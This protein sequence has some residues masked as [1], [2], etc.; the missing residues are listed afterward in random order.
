M[1]FEEEMKA[2]CR[3]NYKKDPCSDTAHIVVS[4]TGFQRFYGAC[5]ILKN[6]ALND[7]DYDPEDYVMMVCMCV[8]TGLRREDV[9][10]E[11]VKAELEEKGG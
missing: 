3:I 6:C 5:E 8:T 2:G 7:S 1:T 4:G 11:T 9:V 10:A